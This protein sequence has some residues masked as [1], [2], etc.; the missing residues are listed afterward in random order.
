MEISSNTTM[1]LGS[2]NTD[3]IE[4]ISPDIKNKMSVQIDT[5]LYCWFD[6]NKVH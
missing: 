5:E 3:K 1:R 6:F 4:N 2:F